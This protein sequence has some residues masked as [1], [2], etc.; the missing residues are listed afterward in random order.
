MPFGVSSAGEVL[1]K[2]NEETFAD[3][4]GVHV[5][6]IIVARNNE[7]HDTTVLKV[8]RRAQER[9]MK[10]RIDKICNSR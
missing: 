7:E 6:I 1:Q 4:E 9:N 2:G 10:F 3:I 5:D 8:M